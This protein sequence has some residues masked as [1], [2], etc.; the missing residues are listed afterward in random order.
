MYVHDMYFNFYEK[1]WKWFF[2]IIG[3]RRDYVQSMTSNILTLWMDALE[4]VD[5]FYSDNA[6]SL[7][8]LLYAAATKISYFWL[9]NCPCLSL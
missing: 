3:K 5:V 8:E 7:L 9:L 1:E 6:E 4:W 2:T